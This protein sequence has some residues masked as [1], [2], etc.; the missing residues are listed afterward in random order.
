MELQNFILFILPTDY[1]L[2]FHQAMLQTTS[3][4]VREYTQT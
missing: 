1:K 4:N 2:F 3:Y